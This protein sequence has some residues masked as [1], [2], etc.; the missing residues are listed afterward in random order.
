MRQLKQGWRWFLLVLG[1]YATGV[2]VVVFSGVSYLIHSAQLLRSFQLQPAALMAERS[3]QYWQLATLLTVSNPPFFQFG[4]TAS[5]L[6]SQ[7]PEQTAD[8]Q[9]WLEQ[10]TAADQ[11]PEVA[12]AALTR[13]QHTVASLSEL[14]HLLDQSRV[15]QA[16][17]RLGIW[18]HVL[19]PT[20]VAMMRPSVWDDFRSLFESYTIGEHDIVVLLQNSRELRATGGFTGSLL[21]IKLHDGIRAEFTIQDI[22]EPDG[23]FT[24]FITP[25]SGLAEY[26]SDGQGLRLPNA[27]WWPDFPQSANQ[28]LRLLALGKQTSAET[29][30]ALNLNVGEEI[31]GI[32]GNLYLPD[33]Q[34]LVTPENLAD[35]ARADRVHFFPGSQQKTAFLHSFLTHLKLKAAETS[36][37]QWL[38]I[39]AVIRRALT[40]KNLQLYSIHPEQQQLFERY[41]VAGLM[42]PD[43]NQL[44]E[45]DYLMLVESNVGINKV[46]PGI[47]RSVTLELT[48]GRHQ[49]TTSFQNSLPLPATAET[50]TVNERSYI[51]YQRVFLP[52]NAQVEALKINDTTTTQFQTERIIT[53][54]GKALTQVGFLISVLPHQSANWQLT[55]ELPPTAEGTFVRSLKIQKQSGLEPTP[56]TLIVDGQTTH[57]L[58]DRD[59]ELSPSSLVQYPQ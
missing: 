3:H 41:Q 30:I 29:V 10:L 53:T 31:L 1:C 36:T 19:R 15:L 42:E 8:L 5:A 45:P 9:L 49:L 59:S 50:A 14:S 12:Q 46:N 24:G 33:Y 22:Y 44:P 2:G 27:N 6:L 43:G 47:S 39:A 25:P 40:L 34:V 32:T 23:Q 16:G 21:W 56:Y 18:S 4:L 57:L 35:V 51:N 20:Q 7:A 13:L 28:I 55:Y 58:L 11:N 54:Q 52:E 48:G 37:V 17:L 26:L 38:E